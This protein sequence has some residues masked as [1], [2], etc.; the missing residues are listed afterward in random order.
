MSESDTTILLD[1]YERLGSVEAKLTNLAKNDE[2]METEVDELKALR[3]KFGGVIME[4]NAK[5]K[6]IHQAIVEF[7]GKNYIFYH[8]D[9][10]PTGEVEIRV[11]E[12][13]VQSAAEVLPI[14]VAGGALAWCKLDA[15]ASKAL[16]T[17]TR[18]EVKA[19]DVD[20][21]QREELMPWRAQSLKNIKGLDVGERRAIF[22]IQTV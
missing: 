15:L 22:K 9:K 2:V 5:V 4:K 16:E 21:K 13:A 20:K 8:N 3:Q 10:L 18:A 12:M 1:I 6:T 19:E 17:A 14:Q 11:H 7:N